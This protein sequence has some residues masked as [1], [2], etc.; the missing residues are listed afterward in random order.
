MK[1]TKIDLFNYDKFLDYMLGKEALAQRIGFS[2]IQDFDRNLKKLKS[3]LD[4]A[5]KAQL[6]YYLHSIKGLAA[7][8]QCQS[9]FIEARRLEE[10]ARIENK[11]ACLP[12]VDHFIR[13]TE[14]T[15]ECLK[16]HFI[17][18]EESR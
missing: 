4:A 9:V 18:P 6:I 12:G 17:K 5:D 11:E 8:V 2:A 10:E 7:I 1:P 14:S 13:L 15:I 3:A 16:E